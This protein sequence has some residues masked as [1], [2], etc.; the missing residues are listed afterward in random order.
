MPFGR[1]MPHR[2]I[3]LKWAL[4]NLDFREWTELKKLGIKYNGVLF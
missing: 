2:R 3:I 4:N 1:R